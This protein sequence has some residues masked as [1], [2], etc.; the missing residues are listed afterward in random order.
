MILAVKAIEG[1]GMVE[2][3]QVFVAVLCTSGDCIFW[4]T[5]PG[6]GGTD[7][8]P[9]TIGGKRV[10]IKRQIPFVRA[11]PS[12]LTV[13]YPSKAAESNSTFMDTALVKTE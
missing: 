9:D 13:F 1:T 4:E 8:R 10:V 7:K 5:A 6:T 11:A 3:G 2:N 12:D